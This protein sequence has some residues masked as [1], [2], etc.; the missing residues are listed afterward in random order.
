MKNYLVVGS[1]SIARRHITN[2]RTLFP[3]AEVACVSASGRQVGE[4]ETDANIVFSNISE[5]LVWR[6]ALAVIASPAPFHIQHSL[7][8]L[9]VGVPVLV[10]KPL[11]DSLGTLNPCLDELGK[12]QDKI[13]VGYN[14]RYLSSAQY[15]KGL[16]DQA[17]V[18]EVLSISVDI[19]QYLPDWRPNEDYRKGV[20]ARREL[21]GGALLEL[22]HEFDYITWIFGAFDD[23]CGVTSCSG[24]LDIDVEDRAD[25]ILSQEGGL[26][27]NLHLDFLQRSATRHCKVVGTD[28]NLLWDLNKN[29]IVLE[30]K[31]VCQ[32]LFEDAGFDRNQM[33]LDQLVNFELLSRGVSTPVVG[34]ASA[35]S[36]IRLIEAV[37]QSVLTRRS[38]S[39]NEMM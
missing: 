17:K 9:G 25:I 26:V 15:M 19:G 37:R 2:L 38:V 23:V 36:I 14:L 32:V 5:A 29:S 35:V 7:Q 4:S 1:G 3:N 20:S 18:G 12:F 8:L 39:L 30:R 21:G 33:Y 28:G 6:P 16:V 31:D 10:E 13:E 34:L 22:S 27:A 24:V 11:S